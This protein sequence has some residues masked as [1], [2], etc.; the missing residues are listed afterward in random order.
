MTT[1]SPDL[2]AA[3]AAA[4]PTL[5]VV[6]RHAG[7]AT[8]VQTRLDRPVRTVAHL[9]AHE[10]EPGARYHGVFPLN[11]AAAICRAS[12]ARIATRPRQPSNA[13]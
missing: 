9:H 11:L 2:L 10:I 13:A 4:L 5:W 1:P 3:P 12:S 7:A 6:T 8:W